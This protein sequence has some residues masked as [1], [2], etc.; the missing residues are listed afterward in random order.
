MKKTIFIG[1]MFFTLSGHSQDTTKVKG[2]TIS[3]E[4]NVIYNNCCGTKII[5]TR[6]VIKDTTIKNTYV[7]LTPQ[8]KRRN[9]RVMWG[10]IGSFVSLIVLG[11]I[12]SN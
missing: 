1:L 10:M 7:P 5:T 4:K 9:K 6:L 12:S 11:T 3:Y 2:D 8:Q